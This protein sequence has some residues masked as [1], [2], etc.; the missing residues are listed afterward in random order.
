MT[1]S[2]QP[3][4][5]PSD[6]A[7]PP[8]KRVLVFN[9]G[10]SSLKFRLLQWPEEI[11]L[12]R[13]AVEPIGSSDATLR[14]ATPGQDTESRSI[15]AGGHSAAV[16][17][18]CER[19]L[20]SGLL[21]GEG[22]DIVAHRFVHGGERFREPAVLDEE[23][24]EQIDRLSPLAPLHNPPNLIGVAEARR[25]FADARH[26]AVF[27]TAF[28]HTMPPHAARYALP[29]KLCAE[30]GV[31]RYGFHGSSHRWASRR[32][33]ELIGRPLQE[34]KTVVLHLG[35]GAS[36]CA[37]DGGRSIDT[38]M[39]L[40]PLEGLVMATRCGNLDPG[41]V[42]YLQRELGRSADD[43]DRLLN[44]ESGL[45]GLAGTADMRQIEQRAAE[46]DSDAALALDMYTYRA[47][48]F[49]GA[50]ATALGRL[51]A[52]VFTA[53]VGENSAT[54]RRGVCERLAVFGV[55]LDAAANEAAS[56][57]RA[58]QSNTSPTAVLV[59]Q[60]NEELQIAR[61]A[62]AAAG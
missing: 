14:F 27:D 8:R 23:S 52:L 55:E 54:V 50:Y 29:A 13:G 38:S 4:H 46:G 6:A 39:G 17:A 12:C 59:V 34:L 18:A 51:D 43:V 2:P 62:V 37:V 9:C 58:I 30:H 44:R 42:L 3:P 24:I 41:V 21:G 7:P 60:A 48:S 57:D 36:A 61:E 22:P 5:A 28:H 53:G 19:L 45:A 16:E 35:A 47:A 26:V 25:R 20:A 31:R 11:E 33:A 1:R 32:A 40:T 56:G 15:D 49:V 10:S